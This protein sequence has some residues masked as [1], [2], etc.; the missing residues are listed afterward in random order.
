MKE[1]IM[2]FLLNEYL[3]DFHLEL[4]DL[5]NNEKLKGVLIP[6]SKAFLNSKLFLY[7]KETIL[8]RVQKEVTFK[9]K[10]DL[11]ITYQRGIARGIQ[12]IEEEVKKFASLELKRKHETDHKTD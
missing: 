12:L 10:N 3:S 6:E 4:P 9:T 1:K 8:S 2:Q 5:E 11:E 7:L